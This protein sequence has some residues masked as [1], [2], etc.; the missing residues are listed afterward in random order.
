MTLKNNRA[1]LL[2]P[3]KLYASFPS[4][5]WI[6]IWVT[7]RKPTNWVLTC[8]T[9]TFDRGPWPFAWTSILSMVITPENFMMIRWKEHSEKGVTDERTDGRTGRQ[10]ER[11]I[12]RATW[13][14]LIIETLSQEIV[15]WMSKMWKSVI[16]WVCTY[17]KCGKAHYQY[18]ELGRVELKLILQVLTAVKQYIDKWVDL[19]RHIIISQVDHQ[20]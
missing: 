15:S 20:K 11:T 17:L 7:V 12:H 1:P 3:F 2:C 9:L 19:V 8:V 10:T 5:R 4:H 13:S 16:R 14:Q 6:P 18:H